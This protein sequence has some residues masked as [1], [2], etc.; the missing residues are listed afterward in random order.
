MKQGIA[1]IN[2]IISDYRPCQAVINCNSRQFEDFDE[3]LQQN[4]S[5]PSGVAWDKVSDE[6]K[7]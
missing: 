4:K 3:K 7:F 5:S 6:Q 1:I 2:I